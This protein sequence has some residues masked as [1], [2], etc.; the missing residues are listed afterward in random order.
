M[1]ICGIMV[2][3][4]SG[5]VINNVTLECV[6]EESSERQRENSKKTYDHIHV[7]CLLLVLMTS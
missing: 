7:K 3:K 5:E 2:Y 1:L 4:R 6:F